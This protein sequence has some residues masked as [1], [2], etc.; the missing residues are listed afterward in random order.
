MIRLNNEELQFCE[1]HKDLIVKLVRTASS[2]YISPEYRDGLITIG[3]KYKIMDCSTCNS[4]L[5]LGTCRL[6]KLYE[7]T[8]LEIKKE[9]ETLKMTL[10]SPNEAAV[11]TN[12]TNNINN[13]TEEKEVP[14]RKRNTIKK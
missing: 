11:E 8:L 7:E 6:Y 5:Y 3:K 10:D 2:S 4:S 13:N 12:S 9:Q 1:K 14:K